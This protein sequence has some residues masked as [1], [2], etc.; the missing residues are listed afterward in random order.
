M[1]PSVVRSRRKENN[2]RD[3]RI[4]PTLLVICESTQINTVKQSQ[5]PLRGAISQKPEI[6][7]ITISIRRHFCFGF[8]WTLINNE[9][10]DSLSLSR[11][12]ESL[13]KGWSPS[14]SRT[15]TYMYNAFFYLATW[16]ALCSGH[17][18]VAEYVTLKRLSCYDN[19]VSLFTWTG[20]GRRRS[21][22]HHGF[23]G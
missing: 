5:Y 10:T 14:F 15:R 21:S 4:E 22:S 17:C 23:P 16:L 20:R 11:G 6:T 3:T 18:N 19:V 9:Y 2:E 13:G 7:I 8:V 1:A 12:R